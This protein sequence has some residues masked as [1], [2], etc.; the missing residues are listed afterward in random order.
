MHECSAGA[1]EADNNN[2]IDID[3]DDIVVEVAA[4]ETEAPR[5]VQDVK[6]AVEENAQP[7]HSVAKESTVKDES[8]YAVVAN[9]SSTKQVSC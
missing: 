5:V 8:E 7:D 9:I 4:T 1:T 2:D 6:A 3:I